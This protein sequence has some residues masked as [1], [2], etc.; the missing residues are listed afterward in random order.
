L[1]AVGH[2]SLGYLLGKALAKFLAVRVNVPLIFVLSIIPDADIL[3]KPLIE[4]RGPT[5]SII[6]LSIAFLPIFIVYRRRAI[7]YFLAI[8]SHPLLGDFF[9]GGSIQLLWPLSKASFGIT[10]ISITSPTNIALEWL[11]FL[12]SIIVMFKVKDVQKFFKADLSN[13]LL[14]IPVFTVLLPTIVRFPLGVPLW[15]EPL[16]LAYTFLFTAAI[17]ITSFKILQER[18]PARNCL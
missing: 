3:F 4:H 15:L 8:A 1:Y 7:P 5:H 13:L 10:S 14:A 12:A 9:I 11:T 17:L 6:V 16:H 18:V 2:F